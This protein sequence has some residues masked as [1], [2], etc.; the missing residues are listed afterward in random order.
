MQVIRKMEDGRW[1]IVGG[2]VYILLA[3]VIVRL[4]LIV[5]KDEWKCKWRIFL[6][7]VPIAIGFHVNFFFRYN[8]YRYQRVSEPISNLY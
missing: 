3:S 1:G 7:F 8:I 6:N 2:I 4:H 5:H